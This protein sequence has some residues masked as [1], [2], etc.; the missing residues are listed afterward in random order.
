MEMD[1]LIVMK[2]GGSVLRDITALESVVDIL[3][4][5][6]ADG[7]QV[8]VVVSAL[9][10]TTDTLL[11]LAHTLS[12]NPPQREQDMLV[13]V[14]ER[15]AMSLLAIACDRRQISAMSFTGS[16]AGI[17][18]TNHH[19]K[20]EIVEIRPHRL[21]SHLHK[22]KVLIVAGFQ[23]MSQEGQITTLGRGG[24]DITAVAL[25]ARL[26]ADV[27]EFFKDVGAVYPQDPK[28]YPMVQPCAQLNYTDAQTIVAQAAHPVLHP[29]ALTLAE[30]HRL[31][32]LVRPF[33]SPSSIGTSIACNT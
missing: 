7:T 18:T 1:R 20:A 26:Q 11:E 27:V 13:S 15:I 25:G 12:P 31:K 23:G 21:Q 5:R 19:G 24:T 2:F 33:C 4:D 9:A 16:Q 14:G 22:G 17:I 10:N 6:M 32:I 30:K 28:I 8:V 29:E 3:L